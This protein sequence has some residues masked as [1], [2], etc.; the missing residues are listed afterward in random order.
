MRPNIRTLEF[1]RTRLMVRRSRSPNESRV[2]VLEDR[3]GYR[4][5]P[6]MWN[7]SEVPHP[8]GRSALPGQHVNGPVIL[9]IHASIAIRTPVDFY[10]RGSR[11]A[12]IDNPG[13][14]SETGDEEVP[15][16]PTF[17]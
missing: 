6:E 14:V 1:G 3:I 17:D 16:F 11:S 7:G 12:D 10:A 2:N 8:N 9:H 15:T 13:K 4:S 5:S